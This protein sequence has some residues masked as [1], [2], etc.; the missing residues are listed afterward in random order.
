[1]TILLTYLLTYLLDF[2]FFLILRIIAVHHLEFKK[3]I[4]FQALM[5]FRIGLCVVMPNFVAIT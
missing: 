2:N 4:N 1:M 5:C 3:K